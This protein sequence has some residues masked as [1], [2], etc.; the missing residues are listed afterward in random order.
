LWKNS[1]DALNTADFQENFGRPQS[2]HMTCLETRQER[3]G[4]F[5]TPFYFFGGQ[6]DNKQNDS[7]GNG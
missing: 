4:D 6:H 5:E 3:A 1:L 7:I 2:W